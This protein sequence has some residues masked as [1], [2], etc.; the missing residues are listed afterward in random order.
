MQYF[1]E[2]SL[3]ITLSG[4]ASCSLIVSSTALGTGCSISLP[5]LRVITAFTSSIPELL[6]EPT[7]WTPFGFGSV[8]EG[9]L[10]FSCTSR[11]LLIFMIE[12]CRL[13]I[14]WLRLLSSPSILLFSVLSIVSILCASCTLIPFCSSKKLP[15]LPPCSSS[16][17]LVP[18]EKRMVVVVVEMRNHIVVW[19]QGAHRQGGWVSRR[20]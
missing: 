13:S 16:I 6:D 15:T 9:N 1:I 20:G 10:P 19:L 5:L 2:S 4:S 8:W 7:S 3:M 12:Y 18:Q 17:W 11:I 14:F